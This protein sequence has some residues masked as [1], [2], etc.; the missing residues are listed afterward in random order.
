[1]PASAD[2]QAE[3]EGVEGRAQ[4]RS[5]LAKQEVARNE[6]KDGLIALESVHDRAESR[7]GLPRTCRVLE[8]SAPSLLLPRFKCAD[9]MRPWYAPLSLG[10]G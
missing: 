8:N 7:E 9:L 4:F 6:N 1:M 3:P 5:P 10:F 2:Q